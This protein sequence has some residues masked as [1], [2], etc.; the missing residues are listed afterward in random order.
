M[1]INK[2]N[3]F[4]PR[5]PIPFTTSQEELYVWFHDTSIVS[6][7]YQS[8]LEKSPGTCNLNPYLYLE[9]A[10]TS[11]KTVTSDTLALHQ[12]LSKIGV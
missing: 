11:T 6:R 2:N 12:T 7:K 1:K 9:K 10:T 3:L 8:Y 4:W 5:P